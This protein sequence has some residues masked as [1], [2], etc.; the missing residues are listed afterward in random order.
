MLPLSL[1]AKNPGRCWGDGWRQSEKSS[2]LS[3]G[4]RTPFLAREARGNPT[5][6]A[7][8]RPEAAGWSMSSSLEVGEAKLPPLMMTGVDPD[9]SPWPRLAPSWPWVAPQG[10][11]GARHSLTVLAWQTHLPASPVAPDLLFTLQTAKCSTLSFRGQG[12]A[13]AGHWAAQACLNC[14]WTCACTR[15]QS[16]FA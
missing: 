4:S 2:V 9:S 16:P 14:P 12:A 11:E 3:A 10:A 13:A 6:V 15:A 8:P 7:S 5:L 1:R